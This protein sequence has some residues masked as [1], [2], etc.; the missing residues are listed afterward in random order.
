MTAYYVFMIISIVTYYLYKADKIIVMRKLYCFFTGAFVLGLFAFRD[1]SLGMFDVE[2]NYTR[3]FYTLANEPLSYIFQRYSSD[4]LFYIF[5]KIVTLFTSNINVYLAIS[6]LPIVCAIGL[7]IYRFSEYPWLS[8]IIFFCLGY[9]SVHVTIMRQSVAMALSIF[10]YMELQQENYKRSVVLWLAAVGFHITAAFSIVLI[11]MKKWKIRINIKTNCMVLG[12][13]V[14]CF[15]FS[16]KIFEIAFSLIS[17]E[18]FTRYSLHL[19]SFNTTLFLINIVQCIFCVILYYWQSAYTK[20]KNNESEYKGTLQQTKNAMLVILLFSLPFYA[21][22]NTFSD[23]YR[24]GLYFSQFVIIA[25]PNFTRKSPIII[26]GF[27]IFALICVYF[28]YGAV[29]GLGEVSPYIA[30][31]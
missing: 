10:M 13:S 7:L 31:L 6:A 12:L 14:L 27:I 22:T 25:I 8:W 3:L 2:K 15:L 18:R 24:I 4:Y 16:D 19:S 28:Y 17:F 11:V 26:R 29:R 30:I 1:I 20:D 9:F 23:I 5:T 21:L